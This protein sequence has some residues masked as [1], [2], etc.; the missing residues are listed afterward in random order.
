[1]VGVI[2]MEKK[3]K[4]LH[5]I[6]SLGD[7]GAEALLYRIC[8]SPIGNRFSHSVI[9]LKSGGKYVDLLK[10]NNIPVFCLRMS[11]F[12]LPIKFLRLVKL[13]RVISPQVVQTWLYHADL[14]GGLAA[15]LAGVKDIIWGI[16]NTNLDW[17]RSSFSS[18][19]VLRTLIP[20]SY[21]VP[22]KIV[23]CAHA[24]KLI[25]IK[26]GYC[27]KKM[28][29]ILNGY[30]TSFFCP[31]L[32]KRQAYRTDLQLNKSTFLV[33]MVARLDPQKDHLTFL[34]SIQRVTKNILNLKCLLVGK[35]VPNLDFEIA[36][37]N[38]TSSVIL[39]D[40]CSDLRGVYNSM[41]VFVL[42]SS[43]GEAFPNVI[44]EAMSCGVPCIAT[45]LGDVS[46]L[47][48]D[49]GIIV[50]P[51]EVGQLADSIEEMYYRSHTKEWNILKSAVRKRIIENFGE[52]KMLESYFRL[53]TGCKI[54]KYP[55]FKFK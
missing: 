37:L 1:M 55:S 21:L 44:A 2:P 33:G 3:I 10:K 45:D 4:V 24:A 25:H 23:C 47:I 51:N 39:R 8:T 26:M 20:L 28:I 41:D 12:N 27:E 5:V 13:I 30:D 17:R 15:K 54:S 16:H 40:S 31:D 29:T 14:F 22:S 38:L 52:A 48:G 7:G 19:L 6:T 11:F 36:E 53:W 49:C 34:K 18:L 43:Y 32:R 42:S 35:N 9:C 46:L 50:P